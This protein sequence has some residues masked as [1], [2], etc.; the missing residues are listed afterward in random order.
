[1]QSEIAGSLSCL[2]A[3]N[4]VGSK[5][6]LAGMSPGENIDCFISTFFSETAR[7]PV[8]EELSLCGTQLDRG[9]SPSELENKP[10]A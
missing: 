6:K 4:P 7:L 3:T 10:P 5:L 2:L 8:D 1:M 9:R